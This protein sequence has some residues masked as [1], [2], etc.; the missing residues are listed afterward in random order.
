MG[1]YINKNFWEKSVRKQ[2]DD[3]KFL[4]DCAQGIWG[5]EQLKERALERKSKTK[6][7]IA[8]PHKVNIAYGM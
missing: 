3:S 2:R 4:K 7:K 5:T 8:T 6:T 1:T